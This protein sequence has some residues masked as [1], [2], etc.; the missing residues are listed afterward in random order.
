MKSLTHFS[1][2]SHF[3]TPE[4][5]RKPLD[6]NGLTCSR[7][8]IE[9]LKRLGH[10]A[11][12]HTIKELETELTLQATESG[13]CTSTGMSLHLKQAKGIAFHNFENNLK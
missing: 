10:T 13:N 3:Y 12:Y 9:I 7:R 8:A 11:S 1:P 2:I 6:Y 5:V 4:N